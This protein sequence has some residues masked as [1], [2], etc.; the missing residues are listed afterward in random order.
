MTKK[1]LRKARLLL[2]IKTGI[3]WLACGSE[4]FPFVSAVDLRIGA[5]VYLLKGINGPFLVRAYVLHH[6]CAIC[7]FLAHFL[8]SAGKA[9]P[10]CFLVGCETKIDAHFELSSA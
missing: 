8:Y 2:I 1:T 4:R 5:V 6:D 10:V 3:E 9:R 7:P